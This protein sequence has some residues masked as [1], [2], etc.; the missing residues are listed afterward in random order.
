MQCLAENAVKYES[1]LKHTTTARARAE[2]KEKKAWGE[3]RV[4]E[5]KLRAVR[6]DLQVVRDELHVV[7]DKLHIKATTLSRVSQEASEAVSSVERLIEEC[8]GLRE[9]L[10]R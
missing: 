5:D 7:R 8:H 3:L 6:D 2:D 9:Y 10:Q 1:D 4:A